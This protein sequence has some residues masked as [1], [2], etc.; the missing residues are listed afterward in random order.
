VGFLW[1]LQAPFRNFAM[2]AAKDYF[3]DSKKRNYLNLLMNL[4]PIERDADRKSMIDYLAACRE[5]TK[6]ATGTL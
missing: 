5:F 6:T 2:I 3:F 4:I 1:L